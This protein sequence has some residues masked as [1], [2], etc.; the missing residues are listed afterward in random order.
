LTAK[1][2]EALQMLK[3][4]IP[5]LLAPSK[6]GEQEARERAW[7]SKECLLR[8]LRAHRW[9]VSSAKK[10]LAETL[11][12]RRIYRPDMIPS[13]EVR[14]EGETG[15]TFPSGFDRVGRPIIYMRPRL[16]NTKASDRQLR[17]VVFILER[18]LAM[19]SP[20]VETVTLVIDYKGASM[21]QS[22]GL[23]TCKS[24][25]HI[26]SH[27]YPERLGKAFVVD[28]PWY[29]FTLFRMLNPF[30]DPVTREK[31]WFVDLE[32]QK[33]MSLEENASSEGSSSSSSASSP[34]DNNKYTSLLYHIDPVMLDEVMG[35]KIHMPFDH[36]PYWTQ[37]L[38]ETGG[39]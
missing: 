3:N 12:W 14:V 5:E 26:L 21:R 9:S 15:K 33:N 20:G 17:Y 8:Y 30:M 18:A 28:G 10:G 35:G 11:E 13:E 29:F 4:A 37:L 2:D 7:L 38:Q 22:P 39:P 6:G 36:G 34:G 19:M 1:E 16:E 27:H 31:V 23:A 24:F 32:R 25:L